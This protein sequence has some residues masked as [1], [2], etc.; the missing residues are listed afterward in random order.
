MSDK[1]SINRREFVKAS[2]VAAASAVLA[3]SLSAA[4]VTPLARKRYAM[5][6]TG[7]RG[8]GMWGKDIFERY[9]NEI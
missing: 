9:S 1:R 2:G 4:I 7:H 8:T 6:G 3:G 5:V